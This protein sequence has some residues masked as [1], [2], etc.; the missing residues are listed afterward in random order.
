MELEP[1][2]CVGSESKTP[3]SLANCSKVMGIKEPETIVLARV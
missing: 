3:F 2:G 1:H